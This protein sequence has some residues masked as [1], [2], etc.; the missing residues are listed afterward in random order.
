MRETKHTEE[1]R[2]YKRADQSTD[3]QRCAQERHILA[4][5]E[6]AYGLR[7]NN[8]EFAKHYA[9]DALAQAQALGFERGVAEALFVQ[10]VVSACAAM[11][12]EALDMLNNARQHF[13]RLNDK[14]G[15]CRV[16]RWFGIVYR[17]IGMHVTSI[18]YFTQSLTLAEELQNQVY[19]S[20]A[21]MNMGE[22]YSVLGDYEK[23]ALYHK[24]AL[25]IA[26]NAN[27]TELQS[28]ALWSVA[29][30]SELQGKFREAYEYYRRSYEL[31]TKQNDTLGIGTSLFGMAS[32][33]YKQGFAA[34]ALRIYFQLWRAFKASLMQL[35]QTEALILLEIGKVYGDSAKPQRAL[36][37]LER[38]LDVARNIAVPSIEARAYEAL[39]QYYKKVKHFERALTCYEEFHRISAEL[40]QREAKQSIQ[41]FRQAFDFERKQ[42]EA[43]IYRLRNEELA[44]V[45]AQNERLLLNI[46][47]EAI[48]Q[49]IKSGE[50]MIAERFDDVTVMF[51]DIV[52]FTELA[53]Q[54]S[55]EEVVDILNRIFSAFDIFSEQYVLEKIKTIG[56]A[57]MI[58]GGVPNPLPN[59]TEAVAN[60]ALEM[61]ETV[62]LL[63]KSMKINITIRVGIHV[64][65]VVAGVI[66]QKKFSY[67]LWGDT[68]NTAYR[69][70]SHG[71]AGKIHCT[72]EVMRRLSSSY[73]FEERGY[74]EV[75]GKGV[76]KTYF[77]L[78]RRTAA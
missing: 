27:D 19:I 2:E 16:A 23:A 74:I 22:S 60:M 21:L 35:P 72:E 41:Y 39:A 50:T 32:T 61:Q 4:L 25:D 5:C 33:L 13:A 46:L 71:E 45:N 43:E 15:Q 12:E 49:R 6:Q 53:S 30:G 7:N 54:R 36:R 52:G 34:R 69:M 76:M 10:G 51:A 3:E 70:E 67:D 78:S 65:A 57:Y 40:V 62:R 37:Y 8:V 14:G 20:Y 28:Q 66:G 17:N 48:A 55:P 29:R 38:A 73:V 42:Q 9:S 1:L 24:Q 58:V 75:K 18:E 59:H 31:R 26:L 63:A 64:G 47:P 68:V 44:K 77:L 11:F 56:D